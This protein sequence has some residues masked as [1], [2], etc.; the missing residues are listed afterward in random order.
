MLSINFCAMHEETRRDQGEP[1]CARCAWRPT[2][3]AEAI[4][5]K[6]AQL[7]R[8]QGSHCFF[9]GPFRDA[10]SEILN[11]RP[12][13]KTGPNTKWAYTLTIM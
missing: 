6:A 4:P 10:I 8:S 12:P 1:V 9:Q 2:A 11:G 7:N 5:K 3:T 13:R